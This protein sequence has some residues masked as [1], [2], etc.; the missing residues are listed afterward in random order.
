MMYQ[1]F[2]R[3]TRTNLALQQ[4]LASARRVFEVLDAPNDVVDRP[5]ARRARAD[6]TREIRFERV[7]FAY[8]GGAPVLHEVDLALPRGSVT[9]LVGPSGRRQVDARVPAPALH[10]PDRRAA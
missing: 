8:P 10:G 9:A 6:L 4:A 2:K 5:G 3:A 7:T 1:P